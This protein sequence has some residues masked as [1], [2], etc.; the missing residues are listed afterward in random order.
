VARAVRVVSTDP[1]CSRS[2]VPSMTRNSRK[3]ALP[4]AVGI[5]LSL[6][7]CGGEDQASEAP[8]AAPTTAAD[9]A[10][11]AF[12][13]VDLT[14]ELRGVTAEPE[15]VTV[16]TQTEAE[17]IVVETTI[18]DPRGD[19]GSPEAQAAIAICEAAVALLESKGATEPAASVMESDGST[20]VVYG[21]PSYPGG[22]S[23]V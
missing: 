9:T 23:E 18:I 7:A 13:E 10:A 12:A 22:C 14:E 6:A 19:S 16:A 4:L 11:P 1:A 8:K 3:K 17:R 20:F 5:V 15:S 2:N 21:Q